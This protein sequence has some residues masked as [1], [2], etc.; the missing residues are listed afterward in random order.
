MSLIATQIPEDVFE[1]IS[2]NAGILLSDFDPE[3]W[4]VDRS[5]IIGATSGGI[6][7]KDAPSYS[8]WGDDIDNCPKNTM[9]LKNL[10]SREVTASGTYVTITPAMLK[11]L[12]GAADL[13][14]DGA[15]ITP[16]AELK[17]DDFTSKL[18]FLT[19]YG[20]GGAIAVRLDNV[21]NA[22]GYSLQTGDKSKGTHSFN[23]MAHYSIDDPDT[24]PYEIYI[25]SGT[26]TG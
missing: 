17:T 5:K 6:N 20:V 8:D 19:D 23:Y 13:S 4:V 2:K 26:V 1:H 21:L 24:V 25:K 3:K 18:W 7:F 15:Q 12:I 14:E 10:D 9:E 22:D 16:R 11:Q